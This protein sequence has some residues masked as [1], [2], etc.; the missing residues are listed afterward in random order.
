MTVSFKVIL[1]YKVMHAHAVLIR[2]YVLLWFY[3]FDAVD[4]D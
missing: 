1:G 2:D 3:L 4:Y